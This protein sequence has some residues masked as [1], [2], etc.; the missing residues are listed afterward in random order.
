MQDIN[1]LAS[2]GLKNGKVFAL[3]VKAPVKV[4]LQDLHISDA[5]HLRKPCLNQTQQ[6]L[7]AS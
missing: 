1:F 2:V 6:V 3:F 5:S 4:S 7:Q